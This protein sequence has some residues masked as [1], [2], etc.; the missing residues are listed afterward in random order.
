MERTIS[1][2]CMRLGMLATTLIMGLGSQQLLAGAEYPSHYGAS[3]ISFDAIAIPG[4]EFNVSDRQ[5]GILD[6]YMFFDSRQYQVNLS[7][8]NN[9]YVSDVAQAVSVG[10]L[11]DTAKI[12]IPAYDV[13]AYTTP[14]GDCDGDDIPDTLHPEVNEVYF[15]GELIGELAGNNS[16]WKFNAEF[17]VPIEKVNFPS[18]PG[19]TATNTVQVAIDVKNKNTVLSSGAVGCRVWATSIDWVGIKFEAT[20][21]VYFLTGLFGVP[22]ALENS[23]YREKLEAELGLYS[24]VVGHSIL[25]GSRT[26]SPGTLVAVADHATNFL[27]QIAQDATNTGTAEIHAIG[28]SMGGLDG[29][30]VSHMLNLDEYLA[31]VGTMD[32]QPIRHPIKVNSLL[33]HGSPHLGTVI[34]DY[35]AIAFGNTLFADMCDLQTNTWEV[36]NKYLEL[37]ETKLVTIGADADGD[38]NQVIDAAEATG[39]QVPPDMNGVDL[40]WASNY[41]YGQ[42]F[43]YDSIRSGYRTVELFG[44]TIEIPWV[45]RD[46]SGPNPNDTFVSDESANG[47]GT[48]VSTM[49]LVGKNH[50]TIID[51][52]TQTRALAVGKSSLGWGD[53]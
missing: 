17:E 33:T 5:A 20:E 9:R 12:Y 1:L 25:T 34:A 8:Q 52:E 30:L 23:G 11:S 22:T 13:D 16:I 6:N 37:G 28:H 24:K 7:I 15:N 31:Q 45:I 44:E 38:G 21:P 40:T 26:C 18:A 4:G 10:S 47:V 53:L 29:R 42:L 27:A 46:A 41:L 48:A 43:T 19:G 51:D 32:G 14:V 49:S 36:A 3:P 35:S 39:N 50:G 2:Q